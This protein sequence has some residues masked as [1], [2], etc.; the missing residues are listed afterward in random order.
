MIKVAVAYTGIPNHHVLRG[1]WR[2]LKPRV[3]MFL[4]RWRSQTDGDVLEIF[5]VAFSDQGPLSLRTSR[6]ERSDHPSD[7]SQACAS[8]GQGRTSGRSDLIVTASPEVSSLAQRAPGGDPSWAGAP[9]SQRFPRGPSLHSAGPPQVREP[10][11]I[12]QK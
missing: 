12:W 8:S 9:T 2:K 1:T 7:R 4:L 10:Q 6:S 11:A 5:R 3:R